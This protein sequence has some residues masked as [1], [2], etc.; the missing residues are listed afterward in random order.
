[1]HTPMIKIWWII[2]IKYRRGRAAA[3]NM[4]ITETGAGKAVDKCIPGLGEK[5]TSS[6][7]E[8]LYPMAHGY[9][10]PTVGTNDQ[11]EG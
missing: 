7:I 2:C 10:K 1:M 4:V 9:T 8:S 6:A 5:L 11:S 3:L